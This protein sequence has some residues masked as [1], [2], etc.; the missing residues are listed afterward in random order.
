MALAVVAAP[1]AYIVGVVIMVMLA[2]TLAQIAR[3]LSSAGGFFTW[4]S[5]GLH[6]R[7]GWFIAWLY[8]LYTPLLPGLVLGLVG[9]ISDQFLQG[10]LRFFASLVGVGP[11]RR[12]AL[13]ACFVSRHQ[14][15][16]APSVDYRLG[17]DTY[18]DR[19]R[20]LEHRESREGRVQPLG[21]QSQLIADYARNL[22]RRGLL[23]RR[24]HGMGVGCL[25]GR[26]N[27][28]PQSQHRNR[29]CGAQS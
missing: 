18:H 22:S 4:M 12:D 29:P 9:Y 19:S 14:A 24:V 11:W 6:P 1:F 21:V 5:R 8:A 15:Q 23:G 20:D 17:R 2:V 27:R 3:Y 28:K 7:W 13:R 10:Q 26:G 25:T 16:R